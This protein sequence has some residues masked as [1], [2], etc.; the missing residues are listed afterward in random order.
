MGRKPP[1]PAREQ[2]SERAKDKE[3]VGKKQEVSK[4]GHHGGK[5]CSL[6][7]ARV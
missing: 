4:S 2:C 5:K 6:Q 7:T 1:S 3:V